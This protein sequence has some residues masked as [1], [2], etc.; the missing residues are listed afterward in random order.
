V[1]HTETHCHGVL[2]EEHGVDVD[3]PHVS[4]RSRVFPRREVWPHIP[5]ATDRQGAAACAAMSFRFG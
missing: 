4:S 3:A 1:A 2:P 5:S